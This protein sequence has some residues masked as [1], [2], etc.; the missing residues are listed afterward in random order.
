MKQIAT[1]LLLITFAMVSIAQD[2]RVAEID[3]NGNITVKKLN[4]PFDHQAQTRS[5]FTQL[6][7]FPFISL[8][9]PS[10][11][12]FRNVSI[13]DLDDDGTSEIAV[14]LN[15]TL[16]VLSSA[17][18]VLWSYQ[19]EGTSNFPPAIADID[20]DGDL[21]IAVQTYGVPVTGNVYLF[22]HKGNLQEGWPLNL[23][24][25]FFLNGITLAD[26]NGDGPLE[27]IAS[28]RISGSSGQVHALDHSAV[29]I[30]ENWPVAVPG[31]PAFT[32]SVADI[33]SDGVMELVTCSTTALYVFDA[34]GQV[35]PGFPLEEVGAKFSYQSPVLA[36]LDGDDNMEII[37]ARHNDIPGTIVVG[38]DG[39]YFKNW[40][41]YDNIWTYAT[42]AVGDIDRD[43][44]LEV[45]YGR[46]YT[47]DLVE[48]G[49]LLGYDHEGNALDG[50]PIQGYAGSEG[51]ISIADVDDD[52]DFEIITGSKTSVDGNG[53]I[54]AYHVET[55]EEVENFPI[56][57][58]GF[59][60]TNGAYLSDVN[61][62]GMLDLTAL[63]YQLK[64]NGASPDSAFI[65][66]FDLEVPYNGSTILFNGYKGSTS[67]AGDYVTTLSSVSNALPKETLEISP[68]PTKYSLLINRELNNLPFSIFNAEGKLINSGKVNNYSIDVASLNSGIYYLK[69]KNEIV[70]FIKID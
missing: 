42:P 49:I 5:T 47:S 66:V 26:I 34:E 50:F 7:G 52:G 35:I 2:T 29:S 44:D 15:Q 21:E 62:D 25:H 65:N 6:E 16:Y 45:F 36:D 55:Q 46:P 28:E 48:G 51:V 39:E 41:D 23:S 38:A 40:P 8:A 30:S 59:T 43:G 18:Q 33:N 13:A 24:N 9:H 11:K 12:N 1:L 27:I 58:K 3:E 4:I 70:K 60:F 54:H 22:D 19:L 53:F 63:S 37:T 69:V 17:G 57:V 56:E 67:H 32:P 61:N 10:F 64:F 14:C 68:N 31:T 20:L